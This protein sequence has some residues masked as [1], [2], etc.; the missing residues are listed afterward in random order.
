[1]PGERDF[2]INISDLILEEIKNAREE[3]LTELVIKILVSQLRGLRENSV[4]QELMLQ[5]D[6]GTE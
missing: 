1:M 5:G 3:D 6:A 4:L 2:Y